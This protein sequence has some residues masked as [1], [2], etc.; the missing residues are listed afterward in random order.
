MEW[1]SLNTDPVVSFAEALAILAKDFGNTSV[2]TRA[3][4]KNVFG[5]DDKSR[6]RETVVDLRFACSKSALRTSGALWLL[7]HVRQS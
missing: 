6:V 2:L 1:C 7:S 5:I 4:M 3:F